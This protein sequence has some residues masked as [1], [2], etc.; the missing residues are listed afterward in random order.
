[1]V[2]YD[3]EYSEFNSIQIN[4]SFEKSIDKKEFFQQLITLR[5]QFIEN[6]SRNQTEKEKLKTF[7]FNIMMAPKDCENHEEN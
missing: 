3:P 2:H 5:D 7:F 6:K 4:I 1:M